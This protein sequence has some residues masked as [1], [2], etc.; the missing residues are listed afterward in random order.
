MPPFQAWH[1]LRDTRCAPALMAQKG[2]HMPLPLH[3]RVDA[4]LADTRTAM[5]LSIAQ[6]NE[7]ERT[8]RGADA[9]LEKNRVGLLT[10]RQLLDRIGP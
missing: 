7:A 4:I 3:T 1:R 6:I 2:A 9:V 8:L 10:S 5:M